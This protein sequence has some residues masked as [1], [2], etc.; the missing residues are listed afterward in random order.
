MSVEPESATTLPSVRPDLNRRPRRRRSLVLLGFAVA[1]L[2]L[3]WWLVATGNS[4]DAVEATGWV[5]SLLIAA[6]LVL[7]AI[8]LLLVALLQLERRRPPAGW[9]VDPEDPTLMRWWDGRAWTAA[10]SERGSAAAQLEPLRANG[11]RRRRLGATM[12][13]GGA[14]TSVV[15]RALAGAIVVPVTD[16]TAPVNPLPM[17]LLQLVVP[18]ALVA[19]VGLFLLLTLPDDV[20]PGWHPDPSDGSALRYWDGRAWTGSTQPR[21]G[22]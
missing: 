1:A 8:I 17:L 2:A 10:T 11:A 13:V 21:T 6:A 20:E 14:V 12:L 7:L 16:P 18:A 5:F 4:P 15:A 22:R 9:V 3:A 19:V